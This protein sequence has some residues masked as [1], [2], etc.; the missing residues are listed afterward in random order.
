MPRIFLA[1]ARRMAVCCLGVLL[2]PLAAHAAAPGATAAPNAFNPAISL[3]LSGVAARFSDDPD[4]YTIPG[5][6]LGEEAGPGDKGLSLSESEITMSANVD[7]LFHGQLT[8]AI[9]PE[10]GIEVEEGFVQTRALPAG[11]TARFG[12]MKS[13]IGY[14]NDRH[15][16]VWDFY[17][18]PLVYRAMFGDQYQ[19]DGA[20]LT[21]L[22]PTALFLEAGGEWFKGE[23]FPAA[24]AVDGGAGAWTV[25]VHAGGDVGVSHAWQAGLSRLVAKAADRED[26]DGMFTGTTDVNVADLV[27]KWAPG[28]NPVERNLTLQ[29]EYLWGDVAGSYDTLG[30]V[31]AGREG[32]YAQAVYQFVRRWR[33]GIRYGA[34]TAD[35]PGAA[36]AGTALDPSGADPR[37]ASAMVDFNGSEFSRVRLQYNHDESG[38]GSDDQIFLQYLMSL[39]THGAH[40]F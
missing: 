10:G 4:G 13:R 2:A 17:D 36:F 1:A 33:A 8:A 27:W 40:A 25:F 29:A 11:V 18:A 26:P 20:R 14:L 9:V 16:H 7:E 5:F 34:V 3:I 35:D 31:D 32:W 19:D 6:V 24:G 38:P 30:A 21:W 12:R 39:G 23:A 22:A 15:A 28:G 37:R